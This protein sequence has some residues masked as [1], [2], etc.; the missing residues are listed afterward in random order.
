MKKN[1]VLSNETLNKAV[2]TAFAEVKGVIPEA[3]FGYV[4]L[5]DYDV[6]ALEVTELIKEVANHF[7]FPYELTEE[8]INDF[9]GNQDWKQLTV[10][11]FTDC[12]CN[13]LGYKMLEDID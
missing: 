9:F 11:K 4:V 1:K 8:D 10:K 6:T 13:L 2:K 5:P 7:D 12:C 3:L